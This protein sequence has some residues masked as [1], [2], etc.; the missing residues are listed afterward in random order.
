MDTSAILST[1]KRQVYILKRY[2]EIL[3]NRKELNFYGSKVKYL[4][5]ERNLK[6]SDII[7][8]ARR[9]IDNEK[10]FSNRE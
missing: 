9:P 7:I 5:N 10:L 1:N 6:N 4:D 2:K 8:L 3:K